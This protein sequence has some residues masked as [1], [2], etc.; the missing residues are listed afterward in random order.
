MDHI[1]QNVKQKTSIMEDYVYVTITKGLQGSCNTV[2]SETDYAFQYK[3]FI[4]NI[5]TCMSK[6]KL[7]VHLTL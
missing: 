2:K 3:V 4:K 6:N 1:Y 5:S 7:S